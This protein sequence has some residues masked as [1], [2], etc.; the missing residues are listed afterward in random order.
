MKSIKT[1]IV[2]DEL[3]IAETIKL[4]LTERGHEV[5]GMAISYQ[6]AIQQINTLE[7]EIVLLDVRLYGNESGIDVARYLMD[8]P[9]EI[10]YVMVS[11]QYDAK[12][13]EDAMYAG[14]SGYI[15][16]PISKETLWATIELAVMKQHTTTVEEKYIDVKVSQGK[17]RIHLEDI[18]YIKSDHVYVQIVCESSK[19]LCRYSLSELLEKID[20][21]DFVQCHRSFI[22]NLKKVKQFS[23]GTIQLGATEIPISNKYKKEILELL[24]RR[25]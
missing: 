9:K 2:E 21:P 6:E 25:P 24:N 12:I 17:H 19:F 5:L 13:I 18:L 4:F 23:S 8:S 10:P 15:T 20:H 7:P 16:K 22:V 11:S 14:A 3:L 1:F